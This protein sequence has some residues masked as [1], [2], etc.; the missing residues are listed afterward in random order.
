MAELVKASASQ[1]RRRR[2]GEER[3]MRKGW[4]DPIYKERG[5]MQARKTRRQ[6]DDYLANWTPQF[7]EGH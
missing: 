6:N 1:G 5:N 3:R 7:M 4:F 2:E